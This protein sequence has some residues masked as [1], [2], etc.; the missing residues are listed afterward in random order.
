MRIRHAQSDVAIGCAHDIAV[1][2][3]VVGQLDFGM[4]RVVAV[5]DKRQAV[6]VFRVFGRTQQ[7]HAEHLGIKIDRA[8][9]IANAKHG[10]KKA[11]GL[12]ISQGLVVLGGINK[13]TLELQQSLRHSDK[14]L[15]AEMMTNTTL[16][17][18][19]PSAWKG[20]TA[21]LD[22]ED[23]KLRLRC[24]RITQLATND[25]QKALLIHDFVK[26][27]PFGCLAA[28]GHVGAAAVLKSGRGDCHTKGTLFVALLRCAGVAARLR[29]VS[30]SGAFLHGIIDLKGSSI[31]HAIGEVYLNGRW[32]QSDTYVA[33]DLLE[34]RAMAKLGSENRVLGYGIH[35]QGRRYWTG[36]EHAHGQY[37]LEDPASLPL[38]DFGVAHDPECFYAGQPRLLEQGSWLTRA[39]WLIAAK[40]INRRTAQLRSVDVSKNA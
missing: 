32:L 24:M 15:H 27:L 28:N 35:A 33:D 3:V 36:L 7:F 11:H 20:A 25:V 29:F 8:L 12:I 26:S 13:L 1:G 18:V 31:T 10:V 6:F 17:D 37:S 23:S 19:D 4:V 40:L 34:A 38:I 21:L 9:E 30:M 2:A 16:S 39:K 14:L 22:L 5:T